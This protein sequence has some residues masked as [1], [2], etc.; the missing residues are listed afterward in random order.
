MTTTIKTELQEE[1]ER[2]M[3]K[4]DLLDIAKGQGI[5]YTIKYEHKAKKLLVGFIQRALRDSSLDIKDPSTLTTN[6]VGPVEYRIV[7]VGKWY[8]NCDLYV[9]GKPIKVGDWS[10]KLE[11]LDYD[12]LFRIAQFLGYE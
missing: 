11:E 12:A 6:C 7:K 1:A 4:R 2:L 10:A 5:L 8:A 3:D 9:H